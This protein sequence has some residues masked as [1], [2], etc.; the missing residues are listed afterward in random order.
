LPV[1]WGRRLPP[2]A[3]AVGLPGQRSGP[4]PVSRSIR[5]LASGVSSAVS[6]A[7]AAGVRRNSPAYM[8]SRQRRNT[9]SR[10]SAQSWSLGRVPSGLIAVMSPAGVSV[11]RGLS[12]NTPAAAAV[13]QAAMSAARS[14]I[15][16]A[17][18]QTLGSAAF[19]QYATLSQVDQIAVA[20]EVSDDTLKPFYDRGT[21]ILVSPPEAGAENR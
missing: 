20:G 12:E 13:A 4:L 19:V 10:R 18:S 9:K 5:G 11:E 2:V 15:V 1:P 16:L 14:V 3:R 17:D 7:P 6:F 8:P 21:S